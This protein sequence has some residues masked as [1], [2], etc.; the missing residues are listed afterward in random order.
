MVYYCTRMG[1]ILYMKIVKLITKI[2]ALILNGAVIIVLLLFFS[3]IYD[4]PESKPFEGPDVFDP[5]RNFDSSIGWKRANFH[6]HTRVKGL[7]NECPQWPDYVGEKYRKLG[8]DIVT[9]SNHNEITEHPT[10]PALQVNVYEQGYNA[11]KFHKLVFGSKGVIHWDNLFPFLASNKQFQIDY[12]HDSAD[13]IQFNHPARTR[14]INKDQ[15]EKLEGYEIIELDSGKTTENEYWDW[16]LSAGHYSFG[17]AND[18]L[19]YPDKSGRIA[20]RCNFVNARSGKYED[21]KECLLDGAYYS[22]R[23][24]DYGEGD[25]EEKY[26]RN[27]HLPSIDK[28]GLL[29]GDTIFAKVSDIADS[30]KI[31]GQDHGVLMKV[32]NTDSIKYGFRPE[33][34][35][36]R[37]T[38]YFP[39]GE[40]IYSNPFARYDASKSKTPAREVSHTV[41]WPLTILYQLVLMIA[42]GLGIWSFIKLLK[43]R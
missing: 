5:Y 28:I 13:F 14:T 26:H 36:A 1:K 3:P 17:L 34:R 2:L 10:D 39:E 9:Y 8:Y 38:I 11:F 40:V 18:D 32:D 6:T 41:N 7:L 35:Y 43:W 19:H 23:V 42:I 12:L 33:D 25:W 4:F 27:Q 20:I 16:A 30:I 22:M 21:L 15:M 37:L 31:F 24:P 29:P